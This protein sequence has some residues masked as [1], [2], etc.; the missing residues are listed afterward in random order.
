MVSLLL[1]LG[2]I[3]GP[4]LLNGWA[5]VGVGLAAVGRTSPPVALRTLVE[6]VS[7][8]I[9]LLVDTMLPGLGI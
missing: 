9:S 6:L 8:G 1:V 5:L 3:L 4:K 7:D 2:L